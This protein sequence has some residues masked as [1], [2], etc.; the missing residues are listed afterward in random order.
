[1]PPLCISASTRGLPCFLSTFT[2]LP[3][4]STGLTAG[5]AAALQSV[6]GKM[7]AVQVQPRSLLPV[8]AAADNFPPFHEPY[9]TRHP[10][11]TEAY[12]PLH[13]TL[14]DHLAGLP[15]IGLLR[16]DVLG[17]LRQLRSPH[18]V[19]HSGGAPGEDGRWKPETHCVYLADDIIE[20]GPEGVGEVIQSLAEK[21]KR[22]G[23]FPGPLGGMSRRTALL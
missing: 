9:P 21:W 3:F 20:E 17:E 2:N 1:M 23:K 11:T 14:A 18:F 8:V 5:I 15:P 16:P 19:E 10:I 22:E 4:F 7:D 12:V 6:T 13:L